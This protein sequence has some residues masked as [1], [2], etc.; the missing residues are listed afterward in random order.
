[1]RSASFLT[2]GGGGASR[3]STITS[4]Y[5]T[6]QYCCSAYDDS[7]IAY[8][9]RSSINFDR[10]ELLVSFGSS[11]T[12]VEC[13]VSDASALAVL[14]VAEN[15]RLDWSYRLCE[16]FLLIEE[17]GSAKIHVIMS[18]HCRVVIV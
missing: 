18:Y 14:I 12:I 4:T 1:M 16:I 3:P 11:S 2:S 7:T 8:L 10:V 5:Y 15:G 9:H 13:D 17:Y 6:S